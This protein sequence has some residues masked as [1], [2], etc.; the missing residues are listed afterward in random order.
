[1][2]GIVSAMESEIVV[3][4]SMM[5]D[6][7]EASCAGM[8]YYVGKIAGIDVA[9]VCCGVGKVNAAMH[10]QALID[11]CAP[12]AII[13][14]GVAGA[15]SPSLKLFDVVIGEELRYHDMQDFVIKGFGPLEYSYHSDKR[16][17]RLA[18][19]L[20]K[21]AIIGKV[22]SG[23][24]FVADEASKRDIEERTKAL[25]VEMEGTAVAHTAYLNNV[26]C[27]VI[28]TISDG[29]DTPPEFVFAAFEKE[30]A[31]RSAQLVLDMLPLIGE[32]LKIRK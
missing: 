3:L 11:R 32:T 1:M 31:R 27:V 5:T 6:K 30:A 26:P 28:R 19:Q 4:R 18:A 7:K 13:H 15:L 25:C 8:P 2:I 14:C 12:I 21:D 16:L 20:N 23:D 29:A 10:T 9:L 17:I 22:A 24:V